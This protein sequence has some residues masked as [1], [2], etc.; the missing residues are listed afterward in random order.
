MSKLDFYKRHLVWIRAISTMP[1]DVR[2]NFSDMMDDTA[3]RLAENIPIEGVPENIP[4]TFKGY[5]QTIIDEMQEDYSK[6][7]LARDRQREGGKK[8]A[9]SKRELQLFENQDKEVL[10]T[11]AAKL[12][13]ISSTTLLTYAKQGLIDYR[14]ENGKYHFT[15]AAILKF[16]E[17]KKKQ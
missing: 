5:A 2:R 7:T 10:S 9:E 1:D 12:L 15:Y 3:I 13:K 14:I 11:Q 4:E 17:T 16:R 6:T 8:A